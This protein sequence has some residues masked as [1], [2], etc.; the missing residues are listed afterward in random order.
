M[1]NDGFTPMRKGII[2]YLFLALFWFV[3]GVALQLFWDT[4][5]PHRFIL[6]DRSVVGFVCFVLFSFNFIRWRLAR[7]RAQARQELDEPP[8][9]R[10]RR[11]YDP[12]F[13]FSDPKPDDKKSEPEG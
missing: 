3:V 6:V 4:L 11:E 12:T 9:P 7:A 13:D 5:E 10:P 1:M 2:V 8:S